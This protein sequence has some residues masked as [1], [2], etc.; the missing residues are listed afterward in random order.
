MEEQ[1]K[2][3]I[4]SENIT[5]KFIFKRLMRESKDFSERFESLFIKYNNNHKYEVYLTDRLYKKYN[6]Y[7]FILDQ[8]Y[9]FKPPQLL[10]D[11]AEYKKLLFN[12]TNVKYRELFIKLFGSICLC[13]DNVLTNNRW[14]P[15]ITLIKII[16]E[17]DIF[18]KYKKAIIYKIMVDK[19]KYKYL[20]N[21]IDLECWLF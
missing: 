6:N 20:N 4:N 21:D 14:S 8:Y 2:K 13:C 15:G 9:P 5:S 12:N 7:C 3:Y 11:N 10:V 17:L 18:R 16:N 19:I 1:I